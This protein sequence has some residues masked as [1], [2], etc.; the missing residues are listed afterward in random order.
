MKIRFIEEDEHN[1]ILMETRNTEWLSSM[2]NEFTQIHITKENKSVVCE[3]NYNV[4]KVLENEMDI[5]VTITDIEEI[6][7]LTIE[8]KQ[9]HK[10]MKT[11]M[12]TNIF[13]EFQPERK[14][15][16]D[17]KKLMKKNIF[18]EYK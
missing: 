14:K 16:K 17:I 7:E 18:E 5:F 11:L 15:R 2:F 1:N 6:E 12:K 4:L 10:D 13:A 8:E 3:Y 9:K